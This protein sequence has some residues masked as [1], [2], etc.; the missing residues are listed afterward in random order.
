[1]QEKVGLY[2]WKVNLC[3]IIVFSL[4]LVYGM[5]DT[6]SVIDLVV[7][8]NWITLQD[9]GNDMKRNNIMNRIDAVFD[10]I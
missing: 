4:F 6:Y 3:I 8:R 2:A 10:I 1:M 5:G 7:L 9:Y